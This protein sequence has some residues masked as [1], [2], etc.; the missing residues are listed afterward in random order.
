MCFIVSACFFSKQPSTKMVVRV[1]LF[2]PP[3]ATQQHLQVPLFE[4][5]QVKDMHPTSPDEQIRLRIF[6]MEPIL[7]PWYK[8]TW[9]SLSLFFFQFLGV[10]NNQKSMWMKLPSNLSNFGGSKYWF[11]MNGKYVNRVSNGVYVSLLYKTSDCSINQPT[12]LT[13]RD[14]NTTSIS[15]TS[16]LKSRGNAKKKCFQSYSPKRL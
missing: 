12:G 7:K 5:S 6:S 13:T 1:S 16:Q 14:F 9:E 11:T 10:K 15:N 2:W 3:Q 4:P 8:S